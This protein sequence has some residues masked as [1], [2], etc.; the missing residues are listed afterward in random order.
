MKRRYDHSVGPLY[1]MVSPFKAPKSDGTALPK[2]AS[3]CAAAAAV[4]STVPA[5]PAAGEQV[6]RPRQG[7]AGCPLVAA[8][9]L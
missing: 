1:G 8:L 6:M 7:N 3:T 4:L 2:N 9:S 5:W